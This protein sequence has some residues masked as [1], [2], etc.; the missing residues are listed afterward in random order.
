MSSRGSGRSSVNSRAVVFQVHNRCRRFG[1][2]TV[3]WRL[4]FKEEEYL[5]IILI[6]VFRLQWAHTA[7]SPCSQA[8]PVDRMSS[9]GSGRHSNWRSFVSSRSVVTKYT[10]VVDNGLDRVIPPIPPPHRPLNN[11]KCLNCYH[12]ERSRRSSTVEEHLLLI[13]MSVFRPQWPHTATSPCTSA[14]RWP[15]WCSWR[16]LPSSTS[17][18][19][20]RPGTTRSTP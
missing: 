17:C 9:R 13:L 4:P 16:A 7:T 14:S 3:D 2:W 10:I 20:G 18:C 6:S 8:E 15:W 19:R 1:L 12:T 5:L 11:S